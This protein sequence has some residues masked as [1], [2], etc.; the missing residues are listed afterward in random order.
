MRKAQSNDDGLCAAAI[1][2]DSSSCW[3]VALKAPKQKP[4]Y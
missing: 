2:D 3:Y 1:A 4:C